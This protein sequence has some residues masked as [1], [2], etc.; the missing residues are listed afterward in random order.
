MKCIVLAAGYATRLYPLTKN[1]PKPL[2]EV[3]GKTILDHLLDDINEKGLV[4]EFV[5]VSNHAFYHHFENWAKEKPY[6]ITLLDD[7]TTSNENRLGAV[8]DIM[9]VIEELS[10]SDDLLVIAGDNLLSFSLGEFLDYFKKMDSTVIMRYFEKDYESL[11]KRG[12]IEKLEGDRVLG[13]VEKSPTP[14]TNWCVPPFYI[15][16]KDDIHLIKE[17]I[18]SG[19]NTDAPGSFTA[20]LT[21]KTLVNSWEMT[22]ERYDIGDI[23]SYEKVKEIFK[24]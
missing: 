14:P 1:F 3:S 12:V 13:M 24:N 17:A 19:V 6:K 16:K 22:G 23:K 8:K 4:D 11:K 7:G 15:Y 20:W 9:F 5:V 10:L 2:L 21:T 18:E